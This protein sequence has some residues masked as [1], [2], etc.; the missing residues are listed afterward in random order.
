MSIR[1]VLALLLCLLF[2]AVWTAYMLTLIL[3]QKPPSETDWLILPTGTVA[4][5][6]A[7]Y[8]EVRRRTKE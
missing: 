5:L 1:D 6:S 2:G 3:H 7:V 8:V 4:M